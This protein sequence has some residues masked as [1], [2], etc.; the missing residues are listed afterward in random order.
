VSVPWA[1]AGSGF[2][3][4]FKAIAISWLK[5]ASL[6]DVGKAL[7]ISWEE[8]LR[9]NGASGEAWAKAS[10]IASGESTRDR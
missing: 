8:A 2:S 5:V 10:S 9:Y 1:E 6:S 4:L 3:A 7:K